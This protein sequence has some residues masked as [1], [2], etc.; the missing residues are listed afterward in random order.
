MASRIPGKMA[1]RPGKRPKSDRDPTSAL[2]SASPPY[3]FRFVAAPGDL[4]PYVNTLYC[5]ATEEPTLAETLPAYSGQLALFLDGSVEIDCPEPA[6]GAIGDAFFLAPQM[7]A[8]SFVA[9]GPVRGVGVSLTAQGWAALTQLPVNLHHS[10]QIAPAQCLSPALVGRIDA[11]L[12]ERRDGQIDD[13]GLCDALIEVLRKG[14]KPLSSR[15]AAL[16]RTTFEWLSESFSPNVE[17]LY[18]RLAYSERQ[19]QRLVTRFFGQPPATLLRRYRAI[20]AA[21]LLAMPTIPADLVAEI[22]A[23]YYD[24][25]HFIRD[26]REFTGK[27]PKRIGPHAESI[28]NDMLSPEGYGM[29]DLFAATPDHAD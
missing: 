9:K 14:I 25:A 12:A 21:S 24:Q 20:R 13:D 26:M 2:P 7:R 5:F 22:R 6:E 16:V 27:T 4:L 23:A 29:V 18:A 8:T 10:R 19:A 3:S 17:E 1:I 15:H 11:L 28:V